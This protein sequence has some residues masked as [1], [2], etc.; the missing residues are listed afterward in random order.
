MARVNDLA[1]IKDNLQNLLDEAAWPR[2]EGE[3]SGCVMHL[4]MTEN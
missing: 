2:Y 4:R 1:V 3:R